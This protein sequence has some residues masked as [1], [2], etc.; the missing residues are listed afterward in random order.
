MATAISTIV[1]NA[2]VDLKETTAS[3]WTDAEL[4]EH[5]KYC[6]NDLWGAVIDL[7]QEHYMTVDTTNVSQAASADTLTGVPADTFRILLIEPKDTTSS[8]TAPDVLYWPRKYNSTPFRNAR[9]LTAQDPLGG[10]D[11]FYSLGQAGSP[12][13]AP[14]VYVAPKISTALTLRF[15][16]VPGPGAAAF[17]LASN[18]P[19]GGE[20]DNAV[21]A[22]IVAHA[23]AKERQDR[24]PDPAWLALYKTEKQNVLT[25]MTPRQTQEPEVVE[26]LFGGYQ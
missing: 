24:M 26:E 10:L 15:V 17:T 14:T 1:A 19:I 9:Q 12:V 13:A 5:A 16:Y 22:W 11:I 25:R 2:R 3:F 21:K 18:N 20:S 7:N 8:G 4:L 6:F 23:R